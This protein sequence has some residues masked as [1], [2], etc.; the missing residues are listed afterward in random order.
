MSGRFRASRF[1]SALR[2][3]PSELELGCFLESMGR[4]MAGHVQAVG[5]SGRMYKAIASSSLKFLV[6]KKITLFL[7]CEVGFFVSRV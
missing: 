4:R 7:K 2:I 5:V 1:S 6:P 3:V